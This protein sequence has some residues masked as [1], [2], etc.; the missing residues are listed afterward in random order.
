M[1]VTHGESHTLR[2]G[3]RNSPERVVRREKYYYKEK[4]KI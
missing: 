1:L 4:T 3:G 2:G